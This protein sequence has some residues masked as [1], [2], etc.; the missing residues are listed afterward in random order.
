[1]RHHH[2]GVLRLV[3]LAEKA[4]PRAVLA[5]A[6]MLQADAAE[7]IADREEKIVVVEVPRAEQLP[8]LAHEPAVRLHLRGRGRQLLGRVRKHVEGHGH[9]RAGVEVEPRE[10]AAGEHGGVHQHLERHGREAH[11][12]ARGRAVAEG[13]RELPAGGQRELRREGDAAHLVA[14]GINQQVGPLHGDHRIRHHDAPAPGL[15]RREEVELGVELGGAGG[16]IHVERIDVARVAAPFDPMAAG[17]KLQAGEGVDRARRRMVA[18]DPLRVVE[19]EAAGRGGNGLAD[20]EDAVREV[21]GVHAEADRARVRPIRRRGRGH[22]ARHCDHQPGQDAK[23]VHPQIT[24]PPRG[25]RRTIFCGLTR[26]RATVCFPADEADGRGSLQAGWRNSSASSAVS[27]S[28]SISC[29]SY[30]G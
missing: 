25:R 17:G 26:T 20:V 30:I 16:D 3:P 14:R 12:G 10:V 4:G 22:D 28:G 5:R 18:G 2:A 8:G 1:M 6:L 23:G 24:S 27:P 19:H 21:G 9:R 13:R 29:V 7:V 15:R 11:R